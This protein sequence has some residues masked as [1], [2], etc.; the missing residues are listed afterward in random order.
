MFTVDADGFVSLSGGS[1]AIDSIAV[2]AVTFPGVSPV[3]PNGSGTITITGLQATAGTINTSIQTRS[4]ALNAL[5]I[6][7]QRSSSSVSAN[8]L[9]NG[10][11]HFKS[12]DFSVDSNGFVTLVDPP[13]QCV[14]IT[15]DIQLAV[16]TCYYTN[17][18][19]G[20]NL[21]LP[22]T[23]SLCD[24]IEITFGLQGLPT[25][26]QNAGQKIQF[27]DMSTTVGV[28]GGIT[29]EGLGDCVKL[30]CVVA[31]TNTRWTVVSSMGNWLIF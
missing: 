22:A 14:E 29:S 20:A 23:A 4:T 27:G 9:L 16:N 26:A 6:E 3:T 18:V 19:E 12:T 10:V 1:L 30:K 13:C 28:T 2:D 24:E 31:G 25:I 7:I 17:F 21:T 11:S 8:A 15:G 5:N